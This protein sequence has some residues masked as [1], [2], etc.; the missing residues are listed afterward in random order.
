VENGEGEPESNVDFG[1]MVLFQ[2]VWVKYTGME[3]ATLKI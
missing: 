2:I 1:W 3:G